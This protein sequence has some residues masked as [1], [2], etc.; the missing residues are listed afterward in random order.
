[1]PL[2][3]CKDVGMISVSK[4]MAERNEHGKFKDYVEAVTRL[5]IK[6]VDKNVIENLIYAG[7]FDAFS[8]LVAIVTSPNFAEAG[9]FSKEKQ[10]E[11]E[12]KLIADFCN[13]DNYSDYFQ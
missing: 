7:A 4:I 1:M 12:L 10:I 5:V 9:G 2:S 11:L 13:N 3:I 8:W 6:G